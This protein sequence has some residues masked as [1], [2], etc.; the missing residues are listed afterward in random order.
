MKS[1]LLLFF[2]VMSISC[3]SQDSIFQLKDYKYRTPGY[4]GLALNVDLSGSY[5][6]ANANN[7]ET[8]RSNYTAL[9]PISADY[10]RIQSTDKRFQ[11]TTV[12]L[13]T[14]YSNNNRKD[15]QEKY[16]LKQFS[17]QAVWKVQTRDYKANQW[18]LEWG[19]ELRGNIRTASNQSGLFKTNSTQQAASN[20]FTIGFGKGRI[21]WVQDAQMAL[22]IL[23]D[24]SSQN[25]LNRLPSSDEAVQ[26]ARLITDINNRR[27]FD[28]RRR[29]V[30]ELSRID[31]FLKNSGLV[32]QTDIRHFTTVNDNW[33]F[34]I[35]PF[36]QSGAAWFARLKPSVSFDR[37]RTDNKFQPQPSY[38]ENRGW[39][40]AFS[41]E[42]GYGAYKPISLK[43][44][45]NFSIAISY[46]GSQ[47]YYQQK[48]A[49]NAGET[50]SKIEGYSGGM[51][52]NT[53]YSIGYFPKTR[54][55]LT[56]ALSLN[57]AYY[58]NY[59]SASSSLNVSAD[60]FLG[61]RTYLRGSIAAS[62]AYDHFDNVP[63]DLTRKN[64]SGGFSLRL[65]HSIF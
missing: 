26:F 22:F 20:A 3:F 18:F 2:L 53:A 47:V 19:N 44:Q 10:F 32:T 1:K 64:F 35:K 17:S 40:L 31:S 49:S 54:T 39:W 48:Q 29:R 30:Y 24:L 63:T 9:G 34:A 7:T 58:K 23:Q 36:R 13:S 42:F 43:W 11:Q 25:L 55:Q 41:P 59:R 6:N 51:N 28:S 60:Y 27:V 37:N 15:Q 21:E 61:Y 45:R 52:L 50:V 16:T 46:S 56:A 65:S 4:Q 38:A 33:A 12:S 8:G 62:Y 14:D 57:G 5:S